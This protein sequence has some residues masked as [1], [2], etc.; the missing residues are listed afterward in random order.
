MAM[1]DS[2]PG[3]CVGVGAQTLEGAAAHLKRPVPMGQLLA[4]LDELVQLGSPT[5]LA[6]A[7][8][9]VH[10]TS[11]SSPQL[12]VVDDNDRT[13]RSIARYFLH[14]GA[15]AT[16]AASGEEALYRVSQRAYTLVLLDA[17]MPGISGWLACRL[18]KTRPY[19]EG[20]KAPKVLVMTRL[21]RPLERWSLLR[22]RCDG[23]LRKPLQKSDLLAVVRP[24]LAK[25]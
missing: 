4:V 23:H 9:P 11:A 8:P 3:R 20:R 15:E 24:Y 16:Y 22:C 19:G 6:G 25:P 18:I 7:A 2:W 10:P 12:L 1:S 5:A 13:R 21:D 17:R 14:L